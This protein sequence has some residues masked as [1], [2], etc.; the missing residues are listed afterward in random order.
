MHKRSGL[1]EGKQGQRGK[2]K[3]GNVMSAWC[4]RERL[5]RSECP[6]F[7]VNCL[8]AGPDLDPVFAFLRLAAPVPT[9]ML[10]NYGRSAAQ[11]ENRCL[12]KP[13]SCTG[14]ISTKTKKPLA[15][16]QA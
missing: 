8:P 13:L 2:K 5:I 1:R 7:R 6:R 4:Q 14:L 15:S 12:E 10:M 16:S 3:T 11:P 9:A